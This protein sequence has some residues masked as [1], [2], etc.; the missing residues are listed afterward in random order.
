MGSATSLPTSTIVPRLN[1]LPP[2]NP[3][4]DNGT[5]S[6]PHVELLTFS[7][8]VLRNVKPKEGLERLPHEVLRK[9]FIDSTFMS[10]V[11]LSLV[12]KHFAAVAGTSHAL[13]VD[14]IISP[15]LDTYHYYMPEMSIICPRPASNS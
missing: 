8:A 14:R 4:R 10:R 11:N 7:Y 3:Y 1:K 5:D 9:I 13:V 15:D 6:L 2:N 12:S